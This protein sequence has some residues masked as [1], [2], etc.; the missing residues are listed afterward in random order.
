MLIW[1]VATASPARAQPGPIN[2]GAPPLAANL[3]RIYFYRA[4]SYSAMAWTAV[5][6]NGA[7]VGDSAPGT[8]FHRDV[9]PGT[10]KIALRT[11]ERYTTQ[12][13]TVAV[14]AGTTSY[15]RI[16]AFKDWSNP[17]T[18]SGSGFGFVGLPYAPDIFG[19]QIVDPG[20]A[21]REMAGLTPKV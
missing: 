18:A 4:E 12:F 13:Q 20:T 21:F 17:G 14:A 1:A 6:L 7:Q 16:Y 8:Y 2:D 3:A 15:V 19:D 10:Y 9:A 11:E 5:F